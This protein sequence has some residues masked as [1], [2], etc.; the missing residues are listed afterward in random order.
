MKAGFLFS[1][2]VFAVLAMPLAAEAQ[3]IVGGS[4]RGAAVGARAAGP[5]GAVVGGVTGGVVGGVVG[6]V[7]GVLGVRYYRHRGHY[8]HARYRH[9]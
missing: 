6:G 3:G 9:Y 1:A 7:G 8:H 4:E 5:I 2:S